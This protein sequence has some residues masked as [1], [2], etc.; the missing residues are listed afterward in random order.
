[1][2][3]KIKFE[4]LKITNYP[5]VAKHFEDMASQGWL[6]D[7]ILFESIFIYKRIEAE[8]LDFAITPYEVETMLTKKTRADLYEFQSVC[9]TVGWNYATRTNDFHIYFKQKGSEAIDLETDEEEE[10]KSIQKIGGKHSTINFFMGFFLLFLTIP[11]LNGRFDSTVLIRA[12]FIQLISVLLPFY[13]IISIVEFVKIQKFLKEN[14]K[15]IELGIGIKYKNSKHYFEKISYLLGFISMLGMIFYGGYIGLVLKN[16]RA[17]LAFVPL[18]LGG[19][20]GLLD[21]IF[22]KPSKISAGKK[23]M[24]FFLSIVTIVVIAFLLDRFNIDEKIKTYNKLNPGDYRVLTSDIFD[25]KEKI[26]DDY[27]NELLREASLFVPKSYDYDYYNEENRYVRTE[28]SYALNEKLAKTL[29]EGYIDQGR[30]QLEQYTWNLGFLL[31]EDDYYAVEEYYGGEVEEAYH[32]TLEANG[33]SLEDFNSLDKTDLDKA[34]K[35]G[36][37]IMKNKAISEDSENL[38]N[39]EEVYFLSYDKTSIVIREGK[40][41]FYLE[42]KDFSDPEII[43]IVKDRLEL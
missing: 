33:L 23:T 39:L 21:K 13:L 10:F 4:V 25:D 12:G 19:T 27:L 2:G 8:E 34:E 7:K 30:N 17:L 43:E 36:V 1:M 26:L 3:Y 22:V 28:Y 32:K 31:Q 41:V 5:S 40:E 16:T 20:I 6:I 15:N 35:E 14:K 38:W 37:E 18:L 42:G 11:V 9:E 24:L 29:V